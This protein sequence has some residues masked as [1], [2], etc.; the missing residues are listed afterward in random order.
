MIKKIANLPGLIADENAWKFLLDKENDL[1]FLYPFWRDLEVLHLDFF[2]YLSSLSHVISGQSL[3]MI[4]I[5]NIK[6]VLLDLITRT[7]VWEFNLTK[8][9]N[10]NLTLKCFLIKI[11]EKKQLTILFTKYP[12]F[13]LLFE[14]IINNYQRYVQ[15]L[16]IRLKQDL[17]DILATFKLDDFSFLSFKIMGDSHCL[18]NRVSK[19]DFQHRITH[20]VKSIV[21][22][23]R[24][25]QLEK[26]FNDYLYFLKCNNP[27]IQL[28]SVIVISNYHYGW[29]EYVKQKTTTPFKATIYYYNLGLLLGICSVF[30]AQDLHFENVIASEEYPIIVDLECLFTPPITEEQYEDQYFPSLFDTLLIPDEIKNTNIT[31]DF[32]ATLNH[33]NQESFMRRFE[34][35][36]DFSNNVYIERCVVNIVP[37][38]NVL[39]NQLTRVP[40]SPSEYSTHITEGYKKYLDW[41]LTN[42]EDLIDFIIQNGSTLKSRILFRSTFIY[43]KIL[44]ESYHPRILSDTKQYYDYLSQLY[45]EDNVI[46]K[47]IYQDE[48]FDLLNGDIPYFST[49]VNTISSTN[50]Q[51]KKIDFV[52]YCSG[53]VRVID[54]INLINTNYICKTVNQ[55]LAALKDRYV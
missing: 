51:D 37:T 36:G 27:D 16:L 1:M 45:K 41:V 25:L 20:E 39:L 53:L 17:C 4:T 34:V 40:F 11:S 38:D 7:L 3:R 35:K 28:K 14:K 29:M 10:I 8:K 22:K 42:K 26:F 23:P 46:H 9:K 5:S 50:S 44:M 54:K 19:I 24:G 12:V 18:G 55:I 52:S 47:C 49:R 6:I 15:T 2:S 32:S 31:Y 13:K 33:P 48:I 43:S 21:Y 30:N